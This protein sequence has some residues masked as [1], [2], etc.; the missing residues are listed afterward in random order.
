MNTGKLIRTL[1]GA[2]NAVTS[3]AISPDGKTLASNNSNQTIQLWN[4]ETGQQLRTLLGYV[5]EDAEYVNSVAFSP[6]S[7]TLVSGNGD[8]RINIWQMP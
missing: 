1:N 7:Q 3:L 5:G 2:T 6:N 8:G 4:L